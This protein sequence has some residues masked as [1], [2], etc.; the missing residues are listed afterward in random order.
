[1]S[2]NQMEEISVLRNDIEGQIEILEKRILDDQLTL[3]SLKLRLKELIIQEKERAC[4]LSS[5]EILDLI[6]E[7]TGKESNMSTIKRWSDQGFLGEAIDEREVFWALKTKQ[8]KKRFL[9]PKKQV[10]QFLY[11]KKWIRPR[12]DVLDRVKICKPGT[13]YHEEAAV[14]VKSR[15]EADEFLYTLQ[16]ENDF[17]VLQDITESCLSLI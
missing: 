14:V 2:P 7:H 9:Y 10:Y 16:T 8:G 6:Y 11:D 17:L 5:S 12:F 4:Y 15:L 13:P 1:M 3:Q